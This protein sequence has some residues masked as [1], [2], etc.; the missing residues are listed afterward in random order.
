MDD[1]LTRFKEFVRSHGYE[2]VISDHGISI[3][4]LIGSLKTEQDSCGGDDD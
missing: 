2:L 1:L 4:E 3:E